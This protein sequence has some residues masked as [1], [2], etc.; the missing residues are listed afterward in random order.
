MANFIK[1]F[2]IIEPF[3]YSEAAASIFNGHTKF[4]TLIFNID[5][6]N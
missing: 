6:S 2:N 4:K 1:D 3:Y 5:C